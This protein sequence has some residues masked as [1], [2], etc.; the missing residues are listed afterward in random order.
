MRGYTSYVKSDRYSAA[1]VSFS[2]LTLYC[3]CQHCQQ[4]CPLSSPSNYSEQ[5]HPCSRRDTFTAG[6][7]PQSELLVT[8]KLYLSQGCCSRAPQLWRCARGTF[9]CPTQ[10]GPAGESIDLQQPSG[11]VLIFGSVPTF[12]ILIINGRN[13]GCFVP[14]QAKG[15]LQYF[16]H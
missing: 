7:L 1:S 5:T 16:G 12:L 10:H 15:E 3:T 14:E 11:N 8:D 6:K 4:T 9:A 2:L 13:S